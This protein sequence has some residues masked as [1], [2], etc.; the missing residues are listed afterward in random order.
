MQEQNKVTFHK[1]DLIHEQVIKN[2]KFCNKFIIS[3]LINLLNFK[4]IYFKA[5]FFK[6][7]IFFLNISS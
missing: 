2:K 7:F 6:Y 1:I 4:Q 5:I 3:F